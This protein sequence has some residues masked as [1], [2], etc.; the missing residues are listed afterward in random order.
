MPSSIEQKLNNWD[1]KSTDTISSIYNQYVN[2]KVFIPTLVTLTKSTQLQKGA[3]WLLKKYCENALK[4]SDNHIVEIYQN[5]CSLTSWEAKLHILQCIS[6]MP[7]KHVSVKAV[8]IFLRQCLSERNKFVRAWAYHG[9]YELATQHPTF[10]QEVKAFFEMALR[11][12][13]ASVKARIRNILK[14]PEAKWLKQ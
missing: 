13:P 9:F 14:Q 10:Q 5:T 8:E 12:E 11:D 7:I 1:G 6:Y 4:L 2:S 3:T